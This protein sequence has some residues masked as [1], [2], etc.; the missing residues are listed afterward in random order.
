MK[1]IVGLGN[2]GK[3]YE[4]TRHNI[5]FFVLDNYLGK[6]INWQKDKFA[7]IYKEKK[8]NDTIIYIKPTT[9]MNLSGDAVRYYS[10]YYKIA[11]EDILIIQ[12]DM[13]LPIGATRIKINSSAGGH[14]GIK[15]IINKLKTDKFARLKVGIGNPSF[16]VVDF[17]LGKFS[18]SDQKILN[19]NIKIYNNILDDFINNT[20]IDR[21]MNRYN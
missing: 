4:N 13:T 16:D 19:D 1:L 10:D 12:D 9:F 15:D 17:V 14:N 6:N 11:I 7:Y 8:N 18:S 2:I 3:E 20:Q 5:G 21:I